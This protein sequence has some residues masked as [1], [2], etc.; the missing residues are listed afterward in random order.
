MPDP[1]PILLVEDTLDGQVIYQVALEH[2]GYAVTTAAN[3]YDALLEMRRQRPALV[4]LDLL[5]PGV[6]GWDVMREI[7]DDDTLRDV[8]VVCI[9]AQAFPELRERAFALG[10]RS[11]LVKPLAPRDLLN[12]V[13]MLL[14]EPHS[15]SRARQ[16]QL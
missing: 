15:R 5:L 13:R 10:C 16:R 7:R 8:P 3:G 1:A 14:G 6:D 9:T 11:Y 12:E 2:A 4:L